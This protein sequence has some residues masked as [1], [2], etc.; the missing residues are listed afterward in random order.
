[1]PNQRGALIMYGRGAEL[2]NFKFF[3]DDLLTTEL[4]EYK[5]NALIK[6]V[7]RRDDFFNLLINPN[8]IIR[9]LHIYSHSIGGGL[10]LG[11]G[12]QDLATERLRE[13]NKSTR[14]KSPNS[15]S[16]QTVLATEQ[17][18]IFTDD[19]IRHPFSDYRDEIRSA[20]T[21]DAKIK[22]WGCNSGVSDWNYSDPIK[23]GV[24][25]TNPSEQAEYYYWRALNEFNIPKP[26]IAQA[27]ANYFQRTT[28]GAGSGSNIQI[29]Y[30][31]RWIASDVFLKTT[32]R[33]S[34]GEADVLRLAPEKGDYNEYKPQ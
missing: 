7:E 13:I 29:L 8:I 9:E 6:K 26:S 10:F 1:M 3:A 27:L 25:T 5:N 32:G 24:Y 15:T 21:P 34:V 11:Y 16:Y 18:T 4:K 28:Y 30:K 2:G 31:S 33:R 23:P 22:I 19:L 14:S 12:D 20:F 17:G